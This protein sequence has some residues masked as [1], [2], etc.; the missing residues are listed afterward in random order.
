MHK[1]NLPGEEHSFKD[2]VKVPRSYVS[3]FVGGKWVYIW[4]SIQVEAPNL[5]YQKLHL[6]VLHHVH[7]RYDAEAPFEKYIYLKSKSL[8]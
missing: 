8:L 1:K 2:L 5:E 4:K 7:V 6:A 3:N